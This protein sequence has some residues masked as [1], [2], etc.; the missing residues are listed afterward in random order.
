[1]SPRPAP[2][3]L[4]P[5]ATLITL[6]R[7]RGP[8]ALDA[9]APAIDTLADTQT[10]AAW[11]GITPATIYRHRRNPPPGQPRWPQPDEI[12]GRSP[13]WTYRTLILH[14]AAMPG[15]GSAGRGRPRSSAAAN[16]M[17]AS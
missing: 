10:A 15:R 5:A 8:A 11:L 12:Y 17:E 3:S 2:A 13:A 9:Y 4:P 1:M 16:D 14:R 7:T 6:A